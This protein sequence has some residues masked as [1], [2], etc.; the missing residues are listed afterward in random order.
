M[1][2]SKAYE[3]YKASKKTVFPKKK[4]SIYG[5]IARSHVVYSGTSGA[6]H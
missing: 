6:I 2:I 3:A 1:F 5:V 4:K